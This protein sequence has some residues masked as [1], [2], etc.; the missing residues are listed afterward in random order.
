[1]DAFKLMKELR[2][3]YEQEVHYL[4][5]KTGLSLI[6]SSV[7]GE[8]RISAK[9]RDAKVEDLWS[10]TSFFGYSTQTFVLAVNLLDRFLA[11]MRIQPKHLSCVSLSCLHMAA[12]VTEEECNLTPCDELIRIGQCRFTVSDLERMEKIVADKLNFKSKAITALTFLHLYH[13]IA[14]SQA[15]DRNETLS[16]EKL[17]AQLKACLCRITFSLAKPS[18]LAL[19]LLMQGIEAVHSE[20]MLEI[21]YHI[22]KHLKIGDGELLLWSERVALCLSDY[23]SPECSKPDHRRLQWIVSRRTAQNLHSYR[24]VPELPTIPEG[25]WDESESEDSSEDGMSSGEE[26]LSSSLGS[27]AEGPYF[28]LHLHKQRLYVP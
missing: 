25:G 12:K 4:P 18:V 24:N 15:T 27:D 22:Q 28:P 20:D 19:A 5:K 8:S 10:L 3:N 2:L 16:L 7:Q 14:R 26:S 23:A 11:M 21:A 17:E 6:E 13:Q 9:C 1:M